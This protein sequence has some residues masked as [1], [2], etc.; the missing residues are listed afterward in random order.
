M[1]L[2]FL[3]LFLKILESNKVQSFI[4]NIHVLNFAE[5]KVRYFDFDDFFNVRFLRAVPLN[6]LGY[7]L[8]EFFINR[9]AFVPIDHGVRE[10][11]EKK[12]FYCDCKHESPTIERTFTGVLWVKG[13][14]L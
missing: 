7:Y 11:K 5:L 13:Q 3:I 4:A 9:F 12:I 10:T 6:V 8:C 2:L 1:V 14:E